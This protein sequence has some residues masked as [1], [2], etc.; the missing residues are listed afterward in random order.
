MRE[1]GQTVIEA[2]PAAEQA[3]MEHVHEVAQMTVFPKANS[4]YQ[5]RTADG[6]QVFMPDAGGVGA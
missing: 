4:W 5:G 2:D 3:W 6:R 1:R